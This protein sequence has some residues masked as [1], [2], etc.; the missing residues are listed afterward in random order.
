MLFATL[1]DIYGDDARR[2]HTGEC[3][4][5]APGYLLNSKTQYLFVYSTC[6]KLCY[7]KRYFLLLHTA[8]AAVV[9]VGWSCML[10]GDLNASHKRRILVNAR[11]WTPKKNPPRRA[12]GEEVK[13]KKTTTRLGWSG[14]SVAARKLVSSSSLNCRARSRALKK[15]CK[16]DGDDGARWLS[17]STCD[18]GS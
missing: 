13:G 14:S 9:V 10:W 1:L 2:G 3:G 18:C 7:L 16:R 4:W 11:R 15:F 12:L 6:H 8:A 5:L 17:R